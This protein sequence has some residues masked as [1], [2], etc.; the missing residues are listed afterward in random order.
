MTGAEH[1]VTQS[2]RPQYRAPPHSTYRWQAGHSQPQKIFRQQNFYP[3]G[4]KYPVR[5]AAPRL[6][7]RK[8]GIIRLPVIASR[9]RHR[10]PAKAHF[11]CQRPPAH[12]SLAQNLL[13]AIAKCRAIY[14]SGDAQRP[15]AT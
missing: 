8:T 14:L 9:L 1:N 10:F 11:R 15:D 5:G 3:S 13:T 4:G 6:I 7:W 2:R 12:K